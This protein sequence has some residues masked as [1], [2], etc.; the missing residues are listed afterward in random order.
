MS[1]DKKPVTKPGEAHRGDD[2]VHYYDVDETNVS[3]TEP[4]ERPRTD[5]AQ[6]PDDGES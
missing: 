2:D 4:S 3:E 6:R 5:G 1:D